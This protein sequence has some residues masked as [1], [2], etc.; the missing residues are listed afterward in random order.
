MR[1]CMVLVAFGLVL[2][3]LLVGAGFLWSGA[4]APPGAVSA[5]APGGL[6]TDTPTTSPSQTA[7]PP[8]ATVTATPTIP[9]RS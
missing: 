5:R 2:S 4:G 1:R 8:D 6:L 9:P 3:G 7:T